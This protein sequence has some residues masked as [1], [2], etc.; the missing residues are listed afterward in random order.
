M[1]FYLQYE[2]TVRGRS[3][4]LENKL[5][6]NKYKDTCNIKN[7]HFITKILFTLL[8][9]SNSFVKN[10]VVQLF[11]EIMAPFSCQYAKISYTV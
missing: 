2:E 6:K 4:R 11:W 5:T 9:H 7:D 1:D 3:F 8:S 10:Q